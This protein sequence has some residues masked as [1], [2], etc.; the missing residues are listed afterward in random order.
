MQGLRGASEAPQ[1]APE[2]HRR[3]K[4]PMKAFWPLSRLCCLLSVVSYALLT[5]PEITE[6]STTE[7]STAV[8]EAPN[9]LPGI[10]SVPAGEYFLAPRGSDEVTAA[11]SRRGGGTSKPYAIVDCT[12]NDLEAMRQLLLVTPEY[13]VTYKRSTMRYF[14]GLPRFFEMCVVAKEAMAAPQSDADTE[15]DTDSEDGFRTLG[16]VVGLVAAAEMPRGTAD[17]LMVAVHK[18][19][20][21]MGLGKA[22]RLSLQLNLHAQQ[23]DCFPL[24]SQQRKQ[25]QS[26]LL[27]GGV[28][29]GVLE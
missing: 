2:E 11:P 19:F 16:R 22:P 17:I 24:Y 4:F 23:N 3:K 8:S 9:A 25:F 20:R 21:R 27:V 29:L 26:L 7:A 18:D 1:C 6:A 15:A 13:P 14:A 28:R 12:E 10:Q 5:S